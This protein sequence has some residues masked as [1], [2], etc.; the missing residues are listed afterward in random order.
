MRNLDVRDGAGAGTKATAAPPRTSVS[1]GVSPRLSGVPTAPRRSSTKPT[2]QGG[3]GGGTTD[4]AMLSSMMSRLSKVEGSLR[5][6]NTEIARQDEV[7]SGLRRQLAV[8][9]EAGAPS[10]AS[11]T[12]R[13]RDLARRC[14]RLERTVHQMETFLADYGMIWVGDDEDEDSDE[15]VGGAAARALVGVSSEV[16]TRTGPHSAAAAATVGAGVAGGVVTPSDYDKILA[17]VAELN[18]LAGEGVG[19]VTRRSDGSARIA[20]PEPVALR[21]YQNGIMLFDGPFRPLDAPITQVR[22]YHHLFSS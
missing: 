18:A 22:A 15:A 14:R 17:H 2:A 13:E 16:P 8:Y 9:E 12:D 5:V 6:A 10:S 11:G 20:M 1:G 19:V 3:A 21:L 4:A 7:I